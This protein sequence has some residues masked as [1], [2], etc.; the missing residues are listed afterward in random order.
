MLLVS[1][2]R[3]ILP[4]ALLEVAMLQGKLSHLAWRCQLLPVA[5]FQ[6]PDPF[7]YVQVL[8]FVLVAP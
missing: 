7:V 3:K 8:A 5:L 2:H 6:S 1:R 4:S